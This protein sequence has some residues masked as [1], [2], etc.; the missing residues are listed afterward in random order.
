MTLEQETVS[1]VLVLTASGRLD[2]QSSAEF[3]S[4]MEALMEP[5]RKFLVD[6][7]GI[8]FV[9]SA[10][11]RAVLGVV[12]KVKSVDGVLA[13]CAMR[14]PVKEVL[15]ITGLLPMVTVFPSRHDGLVALS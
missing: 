12:K 9:S 5:Q 7:S 15:E 1:S 3:L 10:G 13:L 6:F 8:E 11:L 2:G 4:R 14:D